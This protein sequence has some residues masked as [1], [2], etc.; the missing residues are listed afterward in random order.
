[1]AWD[2]LRSG[3]LTAIVLPFSDNQLFDAINSR[4]LLM[5]KGLYISLFVGSICAK[6]WTNGSIT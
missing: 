2:G 5:A 4:L 1:M 3:S 6:K